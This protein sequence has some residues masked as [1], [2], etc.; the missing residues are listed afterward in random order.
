MGEKMSIRKTRYAL[1]YWLR[2]QSDKAIE[3][4][5]LIDC[6]DYQV[7]EGF[8]SL[9]EN[10][11]FK[12]NPSEILESYYDMLEDLARN[13][14]VVESFH[15]AICR[16][17]GSL[18]EAKRAAKAETETAVATGLQEYVEGN[19]VEGPELPSFNPEAKG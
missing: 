13:L 12:D 19:L 16:H 10:E 9:C 11:K 14:L 7:R 2:N 17:F 15:R 4:A 18:Q 1:D 5:K 3:L 6:Q 8:E